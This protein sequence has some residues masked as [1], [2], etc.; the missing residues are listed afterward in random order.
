MKINSLLRKY[1]LSNWFSKLCCLLLAFSLWIWIAYQQIGVD[2]FD[3]EV[4]F[5]E[6]PEEYLVEEDVERIVTVGLRGPKTVLENLSSDDLDLVISLASVD[7][8]KG[9]VEIPVDRWQISYPR[10]LELLDVVPER[11]EVRLNGQAEREVGVVPDLVGEQLAGFDYHSEIEPSTAIISGPEKLIETVE[12]LRLERHNWP[13][14]DESP[15]SYQLSAVSDPGVRV[16]EPENNQFELRL[17]VTPSYVVKRVTDVPV[18]VEETDDRK[19]EIDP[20][21]LNFAVQGPPQLLEGLSVEDIQVVV[22]LPEE[23]GVSIEEARILLPED[24]ELVEGYSEYKMVEVIV[25]EIE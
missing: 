24:V 12:N 20:A 8:E 3:V 23:P 7:L 1:L 14:P 9:S 13:D 16:K 25:E 11:I 19:F 15:V 22:E 6:I 17:S 10:G 4:E 5:A 2:E 21:L 18:E